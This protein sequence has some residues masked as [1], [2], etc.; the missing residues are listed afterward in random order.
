MYII[1]YINIYIYIDIYIHTHIIGQQ[2][3]IGYG[4]PGVIHPFFGGESEQNGYMNPH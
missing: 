2:L 4:H 1:K 3:W